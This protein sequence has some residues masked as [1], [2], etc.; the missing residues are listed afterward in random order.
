MW[1]W[2]LIT[3]VFVTAR[4]T[5]SRASRETDLSIRRTSR[6]IS[7]AVSHPSPSRGSTSSAFYRAPAVP[8]WPSVLGA[9][10]AH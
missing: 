1:M 5:P 9:A 7:T 2:R 3:L 10:M 4:V 6:T 8:R